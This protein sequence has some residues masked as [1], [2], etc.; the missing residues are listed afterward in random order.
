MT[1]LSPRTWRRRAARLL[2][3]ALATGVLGAPMTGCANDKAKRDQAALMAENTEL[4]DRNTQLESA[5]TQLEQQRALLEGE[6]RSA[7]ADGSRAGSRGTTGCEGVSGVTAER[8]GT[9]EVLVTVANDILFDSGKATLKASAKTTL[10][11]VAG[12]LN[13]QY[14]DRLIQVAGFTDTDPIKKSGWKTNERLSAER[15]LAVEEY[16]ASKGVSNDT[17]F[18]S[19][20]GPANPKGTKKDSRRVEILVLNAGR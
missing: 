2:L 13:S 10:D 15:A 20:F 1:G 14:A 3:A 16:L 5:V 12:V 18:V 19:A 7:R 17:M 11:Q 8:L 6:L 4:R 9:G